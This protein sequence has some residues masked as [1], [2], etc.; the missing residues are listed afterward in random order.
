REAIIS[1]MRDRGLSYIEVFTTDTHAVTGMVTGRGYKPLGEGIPFDRIIATTIKVF[2]EAKAKLEPIE[3][4]DHIEVE[5]DDVKIIG[6][7]F[8]E[9]IDKLTETC[10]SYARKLIPTTIILINILIMAYIALLV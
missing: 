5:V 2:E 1:S 10:I 6:R 4:F 7:G 8:L 3:G 9:R